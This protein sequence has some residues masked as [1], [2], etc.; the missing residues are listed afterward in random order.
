MAGKKYFYEIYQKS[1]IVD[2]VEKDNYI[3]NI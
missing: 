1:S 3:K 2:M